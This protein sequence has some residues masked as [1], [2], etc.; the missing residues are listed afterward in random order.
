MI[1]PRKGEADSEA[2]GVSADSGASFAAAVPTLPAF[3]R[4]G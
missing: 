1:L 3:Q 4:E 2:G